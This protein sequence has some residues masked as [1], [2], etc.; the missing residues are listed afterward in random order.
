MTLPDVNV[1]L[2]AVN[3]RCDQHAAAKAWLDA[4][5]RGSTTVGLAWLCLVGFLRLSTKPG[6][7]PRP[8]TVRDAGAVISGWLAMP[9]VTVVHPGPRHVQLLTEMLDATG[10]GG[11]LAN[12]AHLA[13]L[14]IEHR[15]S[16]VSFDRDFARFPGLRWHTPT[17]G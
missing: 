3:S 13:A 14:A 9:T 6:L 17:S 11:N 7:F 1:L 16:V 15:G 10:T 5:V 12:D 8:L 4:A 2:Y